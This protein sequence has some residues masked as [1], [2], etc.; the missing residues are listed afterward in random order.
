[1]PMVTSTPA[2]AT[3]LILT[4]VKDATPWLDGYL[5]GLTRLTYPASAISPGAHNMG[6]GC[7]GLPRLE[8]RHALW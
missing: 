1:M 2:P 6:V 3:V 4:P 5:D 7:W 8:V